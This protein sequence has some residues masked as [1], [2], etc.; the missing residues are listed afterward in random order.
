MHYF[1]E[2]TEYAIMIDGLWYSILDNDL[3]IFNFY[4]IHID[5]KVRFKHLVSLK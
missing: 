3:K 1:V 5:L 4:K 2:L